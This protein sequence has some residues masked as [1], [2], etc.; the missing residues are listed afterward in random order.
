MTARADIL[1]S[2]KSRSSQAVAFRHGH[3]A[4]FARVEVHLSSIKQHTQIRGRRA[5]MLQPTH[6]SFGVPQLYRLPTLLNQAL[7]KK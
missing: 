4:S 2:G 3:S 5:V 1:T 7:G 6:V